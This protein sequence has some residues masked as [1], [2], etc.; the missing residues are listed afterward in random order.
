MSAIPLPK[1]STLKATVA[2]IMVGIVRRAVV[3]AP[4]IIP[5][6]TAFERCSAVI[7]EYPRVL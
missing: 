7:R 2:R 3:F 1:S 4:S 6:L 5:T